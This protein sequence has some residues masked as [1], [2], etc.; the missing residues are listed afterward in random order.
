[1][2]LQVEQLRWTAEHRPDEV[3][4]RRV[5]TGEHLTFAE[6]EAAA[7]RLG[8]GLTKLGVQRGDRVALYLEGDHALAWIT[9][10]AAIHKAGA[11]A[12]PTNTRLTADLSSP[13]C[14]VTPS[15]V[16]SSPPRA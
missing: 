8:R 11:A 13:P 5:D 6:W 3:A 1:M 15:P 14:S 10:Y 16:W 2:A 12:V 7:S 9:S 4:Y